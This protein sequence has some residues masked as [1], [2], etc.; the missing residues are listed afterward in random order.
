MAQLLQGTRLQRRCWRL[1]VIFIR[2]N[3]NFK[4]MR[5]AELMAQRKE[6]VDIVGGTVLK[7]PGDVVGAVILFGFDQEPDQELVHLAVRSEEHTSELQSRG[8][9]VCRLLLEK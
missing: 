9:L 8:H 7:L 3:G 2:L 6:G 1:Q 5:G 4:L